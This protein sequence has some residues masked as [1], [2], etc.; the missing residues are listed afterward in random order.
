MQRIQL[1]LTNT[2]RKKP[3]SRL[4]D[5]DEQL[6]HRR[7]RHL[8]PLQSRKEA[9]EVGHLDLRLGGGGGGRGAVLKGGRE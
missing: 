4:L 1:T 2:D 3:G 5:G 9:V 6:P 7:V 8:D